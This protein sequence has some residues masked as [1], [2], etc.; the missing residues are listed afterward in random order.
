MI[1]KSTKLALPIAALIVLS[2]FA[3]TSFAQ[4][5]DD[6]ARPL[7]KQGSAAMMFTLSGLGTFGI[8][9]PS[10]GSDSGGVIPGVGLKYFISDDMALRVLLAFRSVSGNPANADSSSI[11]PST[12]TFGVGVGAEMH[13]RP[14][15][16]TSPY[17]GAQISFMSAST[18]NGRSGSSQFKTSGSTFGIGV[19]AGFD[20]FFTKGLALGGEVNL[21]FK[22]MGSSSTSG[23]TTYTNQSV[24][25][26]ALAT[27]GNVHFIA[28]F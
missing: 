25:T 11:K 4:E 13:F 7:T 24:T 28:Y 26:I 19:L 5:K 8:G 16:S 10:A 20:W 6:A 23:S 15:F 22:S 17:V 14:L 3:R 1:R 12:S 9:G 21:G 18:D 2:T 27:D